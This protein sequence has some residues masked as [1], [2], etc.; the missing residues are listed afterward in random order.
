M[1][2]P[3]IYAL[4]HP[5]TEEQVAVTFA[6]CSRS[7]APFDESA[8]QV[9]ESRA[10]DFNERW[11][12]GYGHASVAEH[13]VAHLAIEN[14]SRL[15]A[16]HIEDG[17]LS[18]YTEKSSRYQV[19]PEDGFHVPDEVSRLDLSQ[20]YHD[21][22]THLMSTYRDVLESIALLN[23]DRF[24]QHERESQEQWM[25]RLRRESLDDARAL[26]PAATLT[27]LGLTANARSL[28]YLIAR[29]ASSPLTENHFVAES[30]RETGSEIFPSLLQHTEPTPALIRQQQHDHTTAE[31]PPPGAWLIDCDANALALV[32]GALRFS[33]HASQDQSDEFAVRA[34]GRGLGSHDQPPRALELATYLF[35]VTLD[36][37]ALRELRRQRMMTM[38][39][40]PLTALAGHHTPDAVRDSG[41]TQRYEHA[42]ESVR[43]FHEL[44]L[45]RAPPTAAQYAVCHAHYQTVRVNV[46]LREL[47]NIARLRTTAKAHPAIRGP[48]R[49]MTEVVQSLQPSLYDAALRDVV[50]P[51]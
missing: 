22:M 29:L 4:G 30:I 23:R 25:R 24:P 26:L 34:A 44:L 13:A 43:S 5:L 32:A 7:P 17:R 21:T 47:R 6:L 33:G 28:A 36:Y 1:N 19:I 51:E 12:L 3:R 31:S 35:D 50:T 41:A 14:V 37:G 10:A 42:L 39:R 48:V 49:Q 9:S 2:Q 15:A 11:V 45:N 18:S 8:Q 46:N 27:N 38:I 16:D 40:R 20:P